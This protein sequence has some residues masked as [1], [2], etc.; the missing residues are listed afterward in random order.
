MFSGSWP[1]TFSTDPAAGRI[2]QEAE[3]AFGCTSH[4]W[5]SWNLAWSFSCTTSPAYGHRHCPEAHGL[6]FWRCSS[7]SLRSSLELLFQGATVASIFSVGGW[8]IISDFVMLRLMTNCYLSGND[9]VSMTLARCLCR[10]CILLVPFKC[11]WESCGST[12]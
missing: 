7:A 12:C 3:E 6:S 4:R 9:S 2:L 5:S 1:L 11:P 8:R 10:L